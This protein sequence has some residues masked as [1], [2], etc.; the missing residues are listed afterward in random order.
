MGEWM[1]DPVMFQSLDINLGPL[2]VDDSSKQSSRQYFNWK[3][4]PFA[5]AVDTLQ[6]SWTRLQE[7]YTF[8][9]FLMREM[10]PEGE[11]GQG[12]N[13]SASHSMANQYWFVKAPHIMQ[14]CQY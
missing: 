12:H 9:P 10:P 1:L 7:E 13:C 2:T 14:S 6:T 8:P 3:T 4:D 11:E 5:L